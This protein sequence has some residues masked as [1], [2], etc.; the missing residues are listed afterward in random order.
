MHETVKI[1]LNKLAATNNDLVST[2]RMHETVRGENDEK[3]NKL[4]VINNDLASTIK[5]HETVRGEK[6]EELN[7]LV[8]IN[9]DLVSSVRM[10]ETVRGEN[11][12][13]IK[14][15][16]SINNH[17]VNT[18][19]I[20]ETT[21]AE[22]DEEINK[23]AAI[24]NNL[25]NTIRMHE[26]T[27]D[28]VEKLTV[29]NND[30]I[31]TKLD[32]DK[33]SALLVITNKDL[34]HQIKEYEHINEVHRENIIKLSDKN[35]ELT[36]TVD[37]HEKNKKK[38]EELFTQL[39][40]DLISHQVTSISHTTHTSLVKKMEETLSINDINV[41]QI[42][43]LTAT[44]EEL[45]NTLSKLEQ[46]V[47]TLTEENTKITGI[48]YNNT[49]DL[50]NVS[51]EKDE[52]EKRAKNIAN[53]YIRMKDTFT[54]KLN[55]QL[56]IAKDFEVKYTSEKETNRDLFNQNEMLK[57]EIKIHS[58]YNFANGKNKLDN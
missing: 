39:K 53:E 5:T 41:K 23:L 32:Q 45:K 27:R 33:N 57:N 24:N 20:H 40:G 9:N 35:T 50:E 18:V 19:K 47:K 11:D 54:V 13:K 7:K 31:A 38:Y 8:A 48:I 56:A 15:L 26:T 14:K 37:E 25:V 51:M 29:I 58:Q 30:L 34:S 21:I 43:N 36:E 44:N 52:L 1:E 10:H 22:K 49:G 16:S 3:I 12:E 28:D 42:R 6:D 17:T 4:S 46:S 55:E 2:V